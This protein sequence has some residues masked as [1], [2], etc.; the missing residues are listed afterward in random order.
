MIITAYDDSSVR[1]EAE[2]MGIS[3]FLLKPFEVKE[4]EL[5]LR[6]ALRFSKAVGS[7]H[8]NQ[9]RQTAGF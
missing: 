4:L 9:S 1:E 2:R 5:T 7:L 8:E 3:E 6:R